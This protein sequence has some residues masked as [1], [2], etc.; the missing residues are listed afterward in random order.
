MVLVSATRF[1]VLWRL[2]SSIFTHWSYS[3]SYINSPLLQTV[4]YR[5]QMWIVVSDRVMCKMLPPPSTD[6]KEPWFVLNP[7]NNLS[8]ASLPHLKTS[9]TEY[10]VVLSPFQEL[11]DWMNTRNIKTNKIYQRQFSS[12]PKTQSVKNFIQSNSSET[13]NQNH[14]RGINELQNLWTHRPC[15]AERQH[16]PGLVALGVA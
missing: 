7:Q 9:F 13:L 5:L 11:R 3:H 8:S 16:D 10:T 12:D 15:K 4:L 2:Y 14:Q 1:L 6:H